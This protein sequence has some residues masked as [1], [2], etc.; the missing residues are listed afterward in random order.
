ML[1][2]VYGESTDI[3]ENI[4][5]NLENG[6]LIFT[7]VGNFFTNLRQEFGEGN[8]NNEDSYYDLKLG[9]GCNLDKDRLSIIAKLCSDFVSY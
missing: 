2:Y 9:L 1:L 7:I 5:E 3:W 4:M 6:S 8:D